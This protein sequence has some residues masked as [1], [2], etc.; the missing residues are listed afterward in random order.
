MRESGELL[1]SIRVAVTESVGLL[2][3]C[4]LIAGTGYALCPMS[5]DGGS[6]TTV[7]NR[8]GYVLVRLG[9]AGY[10]N[11]GMIFAA[12]LGSQCRNE[13]IKGAVG[14]LLAFLMIT[15]LL[16]P[17]SVSIL[18]PIMK[19]HAVYRTSFG[20]LAGIL[21]GIWT[22]IWMRRKKDT[23]TPGWVL[24]GLAGT[25]MI[26]FALMALLPVMYEGIQAFSLWLKS[27]GIISAVI[28]PVLNRVFTP[29][30]FHHPMNEVFLAPDLAGFRSGQAYELSL[31]WG[32]FMSGFFAPM[33]AGIPAAAAACIRYGRGG[34]KET[35]I[36]VLCALSS[37]LFG[38]SELFEY[39][40]LVYCP[41][42]FAAGCVSYG[43][44]SLLSFLCGFRAAI[45]FSGGLA[46]LFLTSIMP[47]A[48]GTLWIL[49]LSVLAAVLW[50]FL[51][52]F[53]LKRIP[54]SSEGK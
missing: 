29:F 14:G 12:F 6:V 35:G 39:L 23:V 38:T 19:D 51:M 43:L 26:S 16:T 5:M 4:A 13:R 1:K 31:P 41:P 47:G 27:Q 8:I 9:G 49:P 30:C 18:V 3:V 50:Y 36:L 33:I 52:K 11:A 44:F 45:V 32:S 37:F 54:D 21:S 24:G 48:S 46:D 53:F 10:D 28:F 2:S 22:M 42:M 40:L 15:S 20:P 25:V 7:Y 17:S 34:Q